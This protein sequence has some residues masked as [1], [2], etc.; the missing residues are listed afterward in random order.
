MIYNYTAQ[1]LDKG[2]IVSYGPEAV[3][4]G[5][6]T[7]EEVYRVITEYGIKKESER[8]EKLYGKVLGTDAMAYLARLVMT[9]M[10]KSFKFSG[11]DK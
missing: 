4:S 11:G 10:L 1:R 3:A 9:E 8:L 6:R 7:V 5:L 2:W